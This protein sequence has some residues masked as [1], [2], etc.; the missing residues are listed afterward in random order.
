MSIE[1]A[2]DT[3]G[4]EL[5]EFQPRGVTLGRTVKALSTSFL[6][7]LE[8]ATS[9]ITVYAS[10]KDVYLKWANNDEDYVTGTNFDEIIPAGQR[11]NF[12]VPLQSDGNLFTRIMLVGRESGATVVVTQK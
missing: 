9:Y 2:F 5:V 3:T 8:S 1:Q 7:S 11:L 12:M 6:I 4:H 10:A